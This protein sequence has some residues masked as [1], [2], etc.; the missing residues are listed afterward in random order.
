LAAAPF[1][2]TGTVTHNPE[3]TPVAASKRL[4]SLDVFRGI[5]IAAMLMV[6]NAGRGTPYAPLEHAE[7]HGWTPTDLIFPFF[8]FIV[9][10]AIPFSLAKRG[11]AQQL[12]T[13]QQFTRIWTRAMSLILLGILLG[14]SNLL[15]P[16]KGAPD[17]FLWSSL[18]RMAGFVLVFASIVALLTPWPW[19]SVSKWLPIGIGAL[20]IA[21]L[22]TM[23]F[24]RAHAIANGWPAD[25]F[26]TAGAFNPDFLRIPG[27]LQRIG[28]CYGVAATIALFAQWRGVLLS[29]LLVCA[30]YSG[31]MLHAK[32]PGTED[33]SVG[34]LTKE[35]NFARFVDESVFDRKDAEGT[36]ITRHTY[37]EYPDPEGIVS[38]LP[39][40]GTALIG[41]LVGFWLRTQKPNSEHAAGLL[42]MGLIVSLAG[43]YLDRVLM[44]INKSL[45]TPSFTVFTAGMAM[46][47]LGVVYWL[48]EVCDRRWWAW[49][50]KVIGMNAITAFVLAVIFVRISR[51]VLVT[52]PT[53][54][55]AV[56]SLGYLN[57]RIIEWVHSASAS[58]QHLNTHFVA[59]DTPQNLSL[60]YALAFVLLVW[61]V[62][63]VM[64]V[65]KVFVKV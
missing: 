60:A 3:P 42:A 11:L 12:T 63:W 30:L 45:W 59:F 62:T 52:E 44:P 4:I 57:N 39:S 49:P 15:W 46:L 1:I 31:L 37:G 64:Y 21:Y 54:G 50:F 18:L 48:I 28:I 43:L 55:K 33:A 5:T 9:G 27:V 38:T 65:C 56:S 36:Y 35:K 58:W 53:T 25:T 51:L 20:L 34:S 47:G 8:L 13:G 2:E 40:I 22:I 14:A 7:W 61:L 16:F 24:V 29:A 23:K 41:I 19:R 32:F 6:N 10:V 26:G 17:G